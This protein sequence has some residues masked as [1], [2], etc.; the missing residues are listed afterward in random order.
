MSL[1]A[2]KLKLIAFTLSVF[3]L[4]LT[5]S[6]AS[7]DPL[8]V[9]KATENAF[10]AIDNN[11][12]GDVDDN[13]ELDN[14]GLITG[15]D[16]YLYSASSV[17]LASLCFEEGG[18]TQCQSH[19]DSGMGNCVGQNRTGNYLC[20]ISTSSGSSSTSTGG[21]ES[22]GGSAG[23]GSGT[24][25]SSSTGTGTGAGSSNSPSLTSNTNGGSDNNGDTAE[26]DGNNG[27][28]SVD[29]KESNDPN[30]N[31]C[32]FFEGVEKCVSLADNGNDCEDAGDGVFYCSSEPDQTPDP[33]FCIPGNEV[34]NGIDDNC[35]G[36]I[37]EGVE[38][39]LQIA[40]IANNIVE[41]PLE[42]SAPA[43]AALFGLGLIAIALITRKTKNS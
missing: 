19:Q 32:L 16:W 34:Y 39:P 28:D 18:T 37:D 13:E 31:V 38:P 10:D 9:C 2:N 8:L 3:P 20:T 43:P 42:V 33:K 21:T 12:D 17:E 4:M 40:R 1:F 36:E 29:S 7:A 15:T 5:V 14:L 22:S 41:E 35:D 6:S 23:T 26:D 11:C 30:T 25:N 24:S 27:D